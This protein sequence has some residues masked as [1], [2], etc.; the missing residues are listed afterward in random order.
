MHAEVDG[1]H[2]PTNAGCE[3]NSCIASTGRIFYDLVKLPSTG[4][5]YNFSGSGANVSSEI[6]STN[7]GV[8]GKT[9]VA[10][11]V[12]LTLTNTRLPTVQ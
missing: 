5:L 7:T 10:D 3:S 9:C 11:L 8:S 6:A 12:H 1:Q 4:T 2:V